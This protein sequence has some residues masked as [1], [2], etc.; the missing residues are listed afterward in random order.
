MAGAS[1][2]ADGQTITAG[3]Y[4]KIPY[5]QITSATAGNQ[6]NY[7]GVCLVSGGPLIAGVYFLSTGAS[8][9]FSAVSANQC[10]QMGQAA[11]PGNKAFGNNQN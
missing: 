2:G 11:G 7:I 9:P 6:A 3:D 10:F 8:V 5:S 1:I 4:V